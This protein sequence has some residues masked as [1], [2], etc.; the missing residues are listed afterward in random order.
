MKLFS[1][2]LALFLLGLLI[3]LLEA[4]CYT[5]PT[6]QPAVKAP[7]D[8]NV[9]AKIG[10]Y[11]ITRED[12]EKRLLRELYPNEYS[13]FSEEAEPPD[14]NSVLMKMIAEKAM[15]T[16]ARKQGYLEDESI[17]KVIQRFREGRL[18]NLLVQNHLQKM[19]DKITAT[20]S[21]IEQR[22][23]ADPNTDRTRVKRILENA[24]ARNIIDQYYKQIYKKFHIK[25]L[26]ENYTQAIQI[27]ERLLNH[28]KTPR[29]PKQLS[30]IRNNQIKNEM[31]TEE[32]NIV[33]ATYDYGQVTLEDWFNTLC[34]PAPPSRPK[35]L[36]T[37]EG[38]EQLLEKA[39]SGPLYISEAKL[40]N[41]DKDENL[42]KQVRDY[43]DRMLH[44][45]ANSEKYKE[46]KEPPST[47][48]MIAY[49]NNNKELFREGKI[50]KIDPIWCQDLETAHQVKVELDSGK[51]FEAVKQKYSLAKEV[52]PFNTY[53]RREGLFWKDLWERD[54]NEIVG[55]IK[56]FAQQGVKWRVVKILSKNPGQIK[57]Y[58]D[59]MN[60]KIRNLMLSEQRTTILAEYRRE[61][62][63]KYSYEI[64][65]ERIK[66]IDP[67][68]IP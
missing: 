63:K 21:E 15:I 66:D 27:H 29:K 34:E 10:D 64:Y 23:Q 4:S 58:T 3:V 13:F 24:K 50:M 42:L 60:N 44:S 37:P 30:F 65:P 48:Q 52:K 25:K 45:K 33:L 59:K 28:P 17:S 68:D 56:G 53:P 2:K 22:I 61:L 9:V 31:T 26:S 36:N 11:I 8:P 39:L 6:T 40:L 55:P 35:N 14:A 51:D 18:V 20:E 46:I 47:E 67:L 5:R 49:F 57:E 19:K 7:A 16:E 12:L 32:K 54:P 43:E 38:V 62:L 1:N 41:L